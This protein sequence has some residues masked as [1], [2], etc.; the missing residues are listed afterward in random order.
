MARWPRKYSNMLSFQKK[1]D[2]LSKGSQT[3]DELLDIELICA[4][5][6]DNSLL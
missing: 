3:V 1:G 2:G 5:R 4:L 6:V